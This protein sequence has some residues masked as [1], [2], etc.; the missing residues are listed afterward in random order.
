MSCTSPLIGYQPI[1]GGPLKFGSEPANSRSITI[2][3]G[4]CMDCRLKRSA[5]W[6]TRCVHEAQ[7]HLNN[8]FVTLT[9]DDR[10]LPQHNS[11]KKEDLQK[12]F[13]RLR[14]HTG[15]LRYYACGEYGDHTNR[16]HYHACIFGMDFTDKRQFKKLGNHN[17]YT[18]Q[19]LDDIWGMGFCTLG[20][21]TFD[22]AAYTASYVHKKLSKGQH[23]YV[24]IDEET[25]EIIPLV[26]PYA[27]MSLRPAIGRTW[28]EKYHQDI[29]GGDRDQFHHQGKTL[30]P[31]KYYDKLFEA[32]SPDEFE[33]L[34][35]ERVNRA[36]A[37]Y[38]DNT[39]TRLEIKE[40]VTQAKL[41]QLKR[42]L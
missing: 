5:E 21:V 20:D 37:R 19:Q 34:K 4:Q 10:N 2:A 32:K 15:K 26:Q 3:C 18:S 31:P 35:S 28:I 33:H 24:R 22:T 39:Q 40:K 25:G 12:F 11:L 14:K 41:T 13:K 29:Y 27:A 9:Y 8:C 36:Q 42:A 7:L 38:L 1:G 16:P 17:L 23:R 30:R 6:A